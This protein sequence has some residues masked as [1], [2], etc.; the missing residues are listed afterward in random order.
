MPFCSLAD[1]YISVRCLL[2]IIS[3]SLLLALSIG[4]IFIAIR[5]YTGFSDY[6][7]RVTGLL[8]ISF[9]SLFMSNLLII[10][11]PWQRYSI[12]LVPFIV[13]WSSFGLLPIFQSV[14]GPKYEQ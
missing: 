10:P 9:L 1:K 12:S 13:L 6:K 3:G 2:L 4:G 7:R 14:S 11:L 8:G 5:S